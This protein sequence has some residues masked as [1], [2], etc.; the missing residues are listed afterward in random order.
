MASVDYMVAAYGEYSASATG[1]NALARDVLAGAAAMY[2]TPSKSHTTDAFENLLLIQMVTVYNNIGTGRM[3]LF[4][5]SLILAILS[6]VITIPVYI[7][8]WK[9]PLIRKR[10]NFACELA[11]LREAAEV[12]SRS[13][14]LVDPGEIASIRWR[15]RNTDQ[16]LGLQTPVQTGADRDGAAANMADARETMPN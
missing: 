3:H 15:F 6:L 13:G 8:Y 11:E 14:T 7:I 4:W 10:S 12:A 9:G 1:G 5:P 16:A 2:S